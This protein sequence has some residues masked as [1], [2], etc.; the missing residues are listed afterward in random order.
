MSE[1]VVENR[2]PKARDILR[3]QAPSRMDQG[4]E[5]FDN[6][7]VAVVAPYSQ[8]PPSELPQL[9]IHASI[10]CKI[11]TVAMLEVVSC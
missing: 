5:D 9:D 6:I 10:L 3:L 7:A 8:M 4:V 1:D 11:R 2:D